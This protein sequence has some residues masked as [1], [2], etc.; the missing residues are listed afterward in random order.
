MFATLGSQEPHL[1]G[2]AW[3]ESLIVRIRRPRAQE[4]S[5]IWNLVRRSESPDPGSRH[6]LPLLVSHFADTCLVAESDGALIGFV[7]GYRPP[8]PPESVRVWQIDVE[9]AFRRQGLGSALLHALIQ[10]PACAGVEY[11]EAAVRT[12]DVAMKRL[13]EGFAR[14]L[15]TACEVTLGPSGIVPPR[16]SGDG[17]DLVRIG[18]IHTHE[19]M[20]PEGFY[21]SL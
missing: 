5:A 19:T 11:L 13:F 3:E 8:S 18:P 2:H 12:A 14:D 4:G 10:C 7:G 17:E 6:V 1:N 16:S 20:S 21:E 9:A 15:D